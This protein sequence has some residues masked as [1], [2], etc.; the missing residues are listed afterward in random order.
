MGIISKLFRRARRLNLLRAEL[1]SIRETSNAAADEQAQAIYEL[2]EAVGVQTGAVRELTEAV[3]LL[4]DRQPGAQPG[5]MHT[6]EGT[7]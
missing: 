6:K 7:S 1:A 4:Q 5:G 3:R 2:T